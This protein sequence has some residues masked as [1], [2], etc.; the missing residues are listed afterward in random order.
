MSWR[1]IEVD[2]AELQQDAVW[3]WGGGSACSNTSN[4][5]GLVMVWFKYITI[6]FQ[7]KMIIDMFYKWQ[8]ADMLN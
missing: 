8:T 4:L 3:T 1:D 7:L 6:I 2:G 5:V